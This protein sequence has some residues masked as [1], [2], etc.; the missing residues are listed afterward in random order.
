METLQTLRRRIDNAEDMQSV[1]KTMKA[2]AAVKIRQYEASV[3]SLAHYNRTLRLAFQILFREGRPRVAETTTPTRFGAILFGSDQGMC[4]QFNDE[5]ASYF[6]DYRDELTGAGGDWTVS[7]VGARLFGRLEEAGI[8]AAQPVE[9]PGSLPGVTRLVQE[10]LPR[11]EAWHTSQRIDR[12][13][14]FYNRRTSA[15]TYRPWHFRLLPM[16]LRDILESEE[17]EPP[18]RTLPM[19][20]MDRDR[21]FSALFRQYLFVMLYRACAESL[22]SENAS[23]ISSMQAAEKNVEERLTEFRATFNQ[24]RQTAITE[25]LLDVITGFEALEGDAV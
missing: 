7:V 25:E 22:A 16:D 12:V 14:L 2:L 3:A 11:V 21:M 4:G 15:A 18:F 20:T 17:P 24:L 5:I 6:L 9:L 10:L 8:E 23:R 1:V 13:L 19:F